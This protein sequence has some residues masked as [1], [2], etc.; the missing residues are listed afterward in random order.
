MGHGA[1]QDCVKQGCLQWRA[2][3]LLQLRV[4]G[5]GFFQDGDV[6]VGVFPE[7]EEIFICRL[8]F[9]CVALTTGLK[10]EDLFPAQQIEVR[11]TARARIDDGGKVP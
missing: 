10:P 11:L 3:Q 8:S 2:R 9:R 5:L 6:G 4:L 7:G 1:A